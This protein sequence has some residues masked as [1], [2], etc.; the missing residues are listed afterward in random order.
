MQQA[1]ASFDMHKEQSYHDR[2]GNCDGEGNDEI[3]WPEIDIADDPGRG[4]QHQ[5]GDAC[6]KINFGINDFF[7]YRCPTR[8]NNGNRKHHTIST[9]CQYNP[10]ISTVLWFP[11]EN[12]LRQASSASTSKTPMPTVTWIADRK[13]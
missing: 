6:S 5:Q 1:A 9:K 4:Q 7:H 2:L 3:E 13:S 11:F 12:F 10:A 8:Y